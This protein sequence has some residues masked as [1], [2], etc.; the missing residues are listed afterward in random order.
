VEKMKFEDVVLGWLLGILGTPIVMYFSAMVDRRRFEDTLR[1]ELRELR[2]RLTAMVY[3]LRKYLGTL[4]K[5]NLDWIAAE[6]KIYPSGPERD[7]MLKLVEELGKLSDSQIKEYV[8]SD[9][10]I[11]K[12]KAIPRVSVPYLSSRLEILGLLDGKKQ[13]NLVNLLHYLEVINIK[14]DEVRE[15]NV[16]SFE[17]SNDKN[18]DLASDNAKLAME[19]IVI[20]AE[21]AVG[22]SSN[23]L[24]L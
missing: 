15:W 19:A 8:L 12:T 14:S 10:N 22:C 9:K 17:V 13:R 6:F 20:S 11:Q 7:G 2:F 24:D 1:E 5:K 18:H 16:L 21:R 4:D 23:Y 3:L